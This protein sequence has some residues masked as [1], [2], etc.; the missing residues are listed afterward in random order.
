M[1]VSIS[2]DH[3]VLIYHRPAELEFPFLGFHKVE[4]KIALSKIEHF[5][6][7]FC[8]VFV[9]LLNLPDAFGT[10][11][12]IIKLSLL[13]HFLLGIDPSL[14]HPFTSIQCPWIK[15]CL[16]YTSIIFLLKADIIWTVPY[17]SVSKIRPSIFF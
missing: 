7:T 2:S 17:L 12:K 13:F 16:C 9:M 4:V 15:F 5:R 11:L 10:K 14:N 6:Y 1:H 3:S 8:W